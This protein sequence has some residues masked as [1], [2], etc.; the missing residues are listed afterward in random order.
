[1]AFV[2]QVC[3]M[4]RRLDPFDPA[5]VRI[6]RRRLPKP[7]VDD[8]CMQ[9]EKEARRLLEAPL[10]YP[11][12]ARRPRASQKV[13]I[14]RQP[15]F[16]PECSWSI[17]RDSED[18]FVR[19]IV[20]A[21]RYEAGQIWRLW[22]HTFGSEARLPEAVATELLRDLHAISLS[23]FVEL[24]GAGVDGARYGVDTGALLP[25]A[26]LSWWG[27]APEAWSALRDWY[28]AAVS[29]LEAGLPPS[30]VPLQNVH[31]WVE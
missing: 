31:P 26:S 6:W 24:S 20:Y 23:P 22:R 16:D 27:Q 30:L 21:P 18:W 13:R 17:I 5:A 14:W 29:A 3:T 25:H 9:T 4:T 15:S 10:D 28:G 2:A 8:D 7:Q 1:M 12:L 19:R 11:R